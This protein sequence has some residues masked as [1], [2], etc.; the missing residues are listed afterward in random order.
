MQRLVS[1]ATFVLALSASPHLHAQDQ[2]P[3]KPVRFVVPFLP[4]GAPDV[5]ARVLAQELSARL[6]QQFLVEN[7]TGA[8]GNVATDFVAK[9]AADGYTLLVGS[10]APLVINPH[11][12]RS[13]PYDTFRDLTPVILAGQS[14]FFVVACPKFEANSMSELLTLARK[15]RI[16]F[17]SSGYG[18]NMHL[19]GEALKQRANVPFTHIPYK[20]APPAMAD[21]MSCNVDVGFGAYGTVLPHIKAGKMKALAISSQS[22]DPELP[23]VPTLTEA[24]YPELAKLEAYYGFLAPAKTPPAIVELLNREMQAILR[25]KNIADGFRARGIT[26]IG[27]SA[28]DFGARLAADNVRYAAIVK[29]ADIKAE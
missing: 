1:L 24:G 3:S 10:D 25:T 8:G 20:G 2:Y 19:S 26:V 17:A 29:Q 12:Y 21:V 22:R 23:N 16:S 18:T 28:A 7:R 14:A 5:V 13:I 27:G 6:G 4:G 11:V 15:Q 9:S